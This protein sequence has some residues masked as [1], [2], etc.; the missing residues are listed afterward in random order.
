MSSVSVCGGV[1]EQLLSWARSY[2]VPA[3]HP[4][5]SGARWV[6]LGGALAGEDLRARPAQAREPRRL[7]RGRGSLPADVVSGE[8]HARLLGATAEVIRRDGY[9]DA[10][11]AEIVA[12]AGVSRNV[13]YKLFHTKEEAFIAAQRLGQQEGLAAC[14]KAFFDAPSWPERVWA[15]LLAL[16]TCMRAAPDLTYIVVVEPNA[17]GNRALQ[18][19]IDM[20]RAFTIFLEEGYRQNPRAQ[21]LP[22]ICSDAIAG[23][24][25]ELLYDHATHER[26]DRLPELTPQ[27]AYIALAPFLGPAEAGKFV[28]GKVG[29]AV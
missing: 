13:F 9:A 15:G 23:A 7:P 28:L 26:I 5:H 27:F 22:R 6:E 29:E 14:S 20:L 3:D 17:A 2:G 10:T 19:V 18:H 24:L 8:H 1:R 25:F 12:A 21:Q 16:L 4:R 11:I